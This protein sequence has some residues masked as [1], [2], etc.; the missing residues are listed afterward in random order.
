MNIFKKISI[1]LFILLSLSR[2]NGEG[3]SKIVGDELQREF[4]TLSKLSPAVYYLAYRV[5]ETQSWSVNGSFGNLVANNKTNTRY[6]TTVLRVGDE[7]FDNTHVFK[8]DQAGMSFSATAL[9]LENVDVA[10]KQEIWLQTDRA[11][12]QAKSDYLAKK[13]QIKLDDTKGV[14]DFSSEE[15]E[16][17]STPDLKINFTE[18]DIE[19]W[20]QIARHCSKLFLRDEGIKEGDVSFEYNVN[21]KY[22]ISSE[23]TNVEQN[24]PYVRVMISGLIQSEEGNEMPLYKSFYAESPDKLPTEL[25]LM[26]E[27]NLMVD[28]LIKLK[29]ATLAEPYTGP[30]ILSAEASG[31]FFHE[32]FGHRVEGHRMKDENDGQTFK[33]RMNEKVLPKTLSVSFDPTQRYF[34]NQYLIGNYKY[35]DQ[36]VASRKVKII[37]K[38]VLKNFL[39]SRTPI[40]E[41][42][43]SNGHGRASIG[44]SAVSRQSNMFISSSKPLNNDALRKKLRKECKRQNLE[45]GYFF[46]EVTGGFTTTGRYMPNA[47]NVFPTEV[48]RVY[49]DGRPDVLVRGVDLIGTPL[50]MFSEIE[51]AGDDKDVFTGFCGAESGWVP[52]STISPAIFVKKIETQRKAQLFSKGTLLPTPKLN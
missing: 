27:T 14:S 7:T 20:E 3:I 15:A 52:V 44:S 9:P 47:F 12:K 23:G 11:Y 5:D 17:F 50:S 24:L 46:K 16:I 4:E 18:A 13:N 22:F 36:G 1:A 39:F 33:T 43:K 28:K 42:E 6:L 48:Y 40:E 31:V 34:E 19:A 25:E 10:I 38:G 32:I 49:V 30:A 26:K 8:G 2:V 45:Y 29:N 51:A 21:R 37:E 41:G 35:D